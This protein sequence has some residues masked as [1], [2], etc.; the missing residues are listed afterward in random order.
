[1][2]SPEA[3]TIDPSD[4]PSRLLF[5]RPDLAAQRKQRRKATQLSKW[6]GHNRSAVDILAGCLAMLPDYSV[7]TL[8]EHLA[9]SVEERLRAAD[10]SQQERFSRPEYRVEAA[11]AL[12]WSLLRDPRQKALLKI[13][14]LVDGGPLSPALLEK[15]A[16]AA[17]GELDQLIRAGFC[18]TDARH[19]LGSSATVVDFLQRQEQAPEERERLQFGLIEA[20]RALLVDAEREHD[21]S[22]ELAYRTCWQLCE[23][24]DRQD[25]RASLTHRMTELL[26]MRGETEAARKEAARNLAAS[27]GTGVSCRSD[28][29][30]LLRIDR[31][32]LEVEA[33]H[34]QDGLTALDTLIDECEA[35]ADDDADRAELLGRAQLVR[36]QARAFFLHAADTEAAVRD[37]HSD[38]V[39]AEQASVC[40]LEGLLL[41]RR[42]AHEEARETLQEA[43]AL[44]NRDE[45]LGSTARAAFALSLAQAL[46]AVGR[47]A[48]ATGLLEEARVLSGG[49]LDRQPQA[50]LPLVLHELGILA[51][52]EDRFAAAG[53]FL[54][55]AAML[56][57][58]TLPAA[59]P[60]RLQITYSRG[61][62]HLAYNDTRQAISQFEKVIARAKPNLPGQLHVALM[63]RCA[64]AL[65]WSIE[66]RSKGTLAIEEFRVIRESLEH[67]P[68][69][70]TALAEELQRIEER[71]V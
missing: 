25:L 66:G 50:T 54:D 71:F 53:T 9:A 14:A 48:E 36:N 29:Q 56:A 18:S 62:V 68:G 11:L 49:D 3:E 59:H 31:A 22:L 32:I 43:H 30:L 27:N 69:D 58:S 5:H 39:N 28:L 57:A 51:A 45:P 65:A 67:F 2:P 1:V 64:R 63:A 41:L 15:A 47:S 70:T 19:Y 24:P 40:Q 35:Q 17:A 4:A 10:P 42:G 6:T 7:E 26:R 20:V 44:A 12:G 46:S 61:L 23:Q 55:E 21:E 13:L 8:V 60:T 52:G 34:I 38:P 33:G 16:A 37:L